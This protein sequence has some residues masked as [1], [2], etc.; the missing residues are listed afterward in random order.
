MALDPHMIK[1]FQEDAHDLLL[2]W[3][4]CSLAA[5]NTPADKTYESLLRFA[6]NLKG[7]AALI[8]FTELADAVH[9]LE[10]GL[11]HL[12]S[13][14][15]PPAEPK[16]VAALLDCERG[17]KKWID[18]LVL[19]NKHQPESMH[20]LERIEIW[21]DESR[22]EALNDQDAEN[23]EIKADL[24][25]D[26]TLRIPAVKVDRLIQL[27]GEL[28][29]AQ[30]IVTRGRVEHRL[31]APEVLEAISLS[32]KIVHNLRNSVLDLRMLPMSILMQRLERAA[33]ELSVKLSKPL[34][35][36]ASGQEV[37]LD[38]VVLER[39]FDPLMH[40]I[41]NAIDHGI[42]AREQRKNLA[43]DSVAKIHISADVGATGVIIK[44]SDDG[45][46]L[47]IE[48]IYKRALEKNIVKS[49]DSL[50]ETE[51]INLIFKQGFSTAETITDISGR[52]VGLDVVV[53]EVHHLG[54]QLVVDSQ[55]G[56]G[57]TFTINLPTNV[58]LIDVIVVHVADVAYAIPAQ[59]LMEVI[60]SHELKF[61][62][63]S[64][65]SRMIDLRGRVVP[66]EPLS[67]FLPYKMVSQ[68]MDINFEKSLL[69][70]QYQQSLLGLEVD[71]ILG[72]QQVFVRP[73]RGYLG[74]LPWFSGATVLSNG[75]PCMIINL[76]ALAKD[77]W[78]GRVVNNDRQEKLEHET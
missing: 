61:T 76:L 31:Q 60:S 8:G 2:A 6:H 65:Y 48:K 45:R 33:M 12:K 1:A 54:G 3:E 39:I 30:A 29:L 72:Q 18:G 64:V 42:E 34:R 62:T 69:I 40:I 78:S 19:D 63:S 4:K 67:Q 53:K 47:N 16:V 21:G 35:F 66:V 73:L 23:G 10:D 51:I 56:I 58:S 25:L 41:R 22:I 17:L 74:R 43:K 68:N 44:V 13:K 26:Q 7:N 27:V 5:S 49:T 14:K 70:V 37:S 71:R 15:V 52:G 59:E 50:S 55:Q 46:G 32:D 57:T 11:L 75:E 20:W 28:L 9:R 38:K 24:Q 77:Y 36:T